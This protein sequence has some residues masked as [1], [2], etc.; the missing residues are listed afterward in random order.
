MTPDACWIAQ[1]WII[2][3]ELASRLAAMILIFEHNTGR[4]LA[5]ISGYRT[6][7]AQQRLED[8]GRPTAPVE[9]STHT[10]CPARGADLRMEGFAA[11]VLKQKF[12]EAAILAGLRWGGGSSIDSG[13]IPSDW[14]HVDLGPRMD[15]EAQAYRRRT[16]G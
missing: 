8:Q 13:G 11:P 4:E 14:N 6:P 12:G 15:D 16:Q 9:L 5:V 2:H 10:I 1:E 7:A 3:P